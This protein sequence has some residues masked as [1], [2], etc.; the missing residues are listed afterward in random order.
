MHHCDLVKQSTADIFTCFVF[1]LQSITQNYSIFNTSNTKTS[2]TATSD[3]IMLYLLLGNDIILASYDINTT[4]KIE[5][6]MIWEPKLFST[7]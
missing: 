4:L 6:T 1:E 5:H 2:K 7:L 3:Q